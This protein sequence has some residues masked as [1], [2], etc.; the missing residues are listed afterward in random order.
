M[1]KSNEQYGNLT[2]TKLQITKS[3]NHICINN[4]KIR[5][6]CIGLYKCSDTS[7]IQKKAIQYTHLRN[8]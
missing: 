4:H 8:P 6:T 3:Y 7:K 2:I 5:H 1:Y